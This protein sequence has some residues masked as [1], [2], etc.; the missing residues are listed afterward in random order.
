M[1]ERPIGPIR[2]VFYILIIVS[3]FFLIY[4]FGFREM[5]FFRVPSSSMLPTLRPHDLLL[6]LNEG[7]YVRGDVVVFTDPADPGSYLVKRV[8]AIPGD[9]VAID[10][11]GLILNGHYASEPYMAEPITY[12]FSPP[13][14]VGEGELF[15]LGDNRNSSDD[16]HV[17]GKGIPYDSVVGRVRLIYLPLRRSQ[18]VPSYPLINAAGS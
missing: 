5:R 1:S 12:S 7:D 17:W 10:S 4:F 18:W 9:T 11:G 15:V 3:S 13:V 14:R 6:T 8:V 2:K 16:S